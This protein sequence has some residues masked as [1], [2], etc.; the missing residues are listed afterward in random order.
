VRKTWLEIN[1]Q[2]LE[3]KGRGCSVFINLIIRGFC[4]S[5]FTTKLPGVNGNKDIFQHSEAL[6][7]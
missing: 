7:S 5:A 6:V 3:I 1:N 4:F 2:Q